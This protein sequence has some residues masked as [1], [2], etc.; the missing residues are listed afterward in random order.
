MAGERE[1]F[2]VD[3][4]VPAPPSSRFGGTAWPSGVY[5]RRVQPRCSNRASSGRKNL[6][7][8]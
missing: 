5:R 2:L 4:A 3:V 1:D 6:V 8:S 7:F